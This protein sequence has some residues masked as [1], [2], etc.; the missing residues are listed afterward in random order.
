MN[1]IGISGSLRK[2]SFNTAALRAAQG[3]APEGMT[4]E[5]AQ[6]GD[7]PLYNDDVRAAGFP[8]PAERLR[9]QLAAADAILLVTPEYNYS[10]SGVLKNAIDWASRPPNQPFE[11]KPVAI[12]GASPGLFGSARAQY[13]LRQML[14]FLNAMPLNRPEVMIGQAQNKFDADGNLTDEPTREF[15]RKLLVAL[16]DWTERLQKSAA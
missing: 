4:I 12:M 5:V 6:I 7:L 3:L 16:R 10:I 13:H 15:V 11:A 1:V 8:P 2:G 9:A 14:I